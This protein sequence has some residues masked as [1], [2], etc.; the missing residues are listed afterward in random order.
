M[1]VHAVY[2]LAGLCKDEL[3]NLGMTRSASEA[4]GVV[5]FISG[6]NGFFHDGEVA[7]VARVIALA[8]DG[9]TVGEEENIVSLGADLV[10]ALCA[11]EAFDV[12]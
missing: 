7:D 5:R 9:M 10:L 11:A 8:A 4:R 3:F 6:H 2:A 1:A 12:P